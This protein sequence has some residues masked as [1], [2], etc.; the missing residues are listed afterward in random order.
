MNVDHLDM[1]LAQGWLKAKLA[2]FLREKETLGSEVSSE[3]LWPHRQAV[4]CGDY[5]LMFG[6][7]WSSTLWPKQDASLWIVEI[8][9]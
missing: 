8:E 2:L 4:P 9:G 3:L 5:L 6:T 1:N 7:K